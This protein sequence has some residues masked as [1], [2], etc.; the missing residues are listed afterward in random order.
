PMPREPPVTRATLPSTEKRFVIDG[1]MPRRREEGKGWS[2]GRHACSAT[3]VRRRARAA[4]DRGGGRMAAGARIGRN[5]PCPCGSGRKY[6]EPQG[7]SPARREAPFTPRIVA[8]LSPRGLHPAWRLLGVTDPRGDAPCHEPRLG[9]RRRR[10]SARAAEAE[11][12]LCEASRGMPVAHGEHVGPAPG[13]P[14]VRRGGMLA[15]LARDQALSRP[16]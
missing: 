3:K 15:A 4:G 10:R 16:P 7:T 1:T 13:E 11:G 12:R 6:C 9:N 2:P 14:G 5:D 8:R